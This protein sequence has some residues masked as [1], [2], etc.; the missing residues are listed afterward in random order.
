VTLL[1]F[2]N[3]APDVFSAISGVENMKNDDVGLVFGALLGTYGN[4]QNAMFA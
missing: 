2:G 3:G 1:A 4:M